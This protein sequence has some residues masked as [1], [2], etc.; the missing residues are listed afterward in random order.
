MPRY[1][2]ILLL[3]QP[4]PLRL[5]STLG[6]QTPGCWLSVER[7]TSPASQPNVAS[8]IARIAVAVICRGPLRFGIWPLARS[9]PGPQH[10]WSNWSGASSLRAA[11]AGPDGREPKQDC[12]NHP[13]ER[14]KLWCNRLRPSTHP[15]G[16]GGSDSWRRWQGMLRFSRWFLPEDMGTAC[17]CRR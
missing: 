9:I 8:C 2:C 3:N 4:P 6:H 13:S 5:R 10:C 1:Y 11:T 17:L 14:A 7:L 16:T 15:A 12:C